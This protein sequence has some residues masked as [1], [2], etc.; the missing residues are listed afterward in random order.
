MDEKDKGTEGL[1]DKKVQIKAK[2]EKNQELILEHQMEEWRYLNEY[3]NKINLDYQRAIMLI[4]AI[5]A[6]LLAVFSNEKDKIDP[7]VVMIIPPV[8]LV[9]DAWQS[10]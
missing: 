2:R 9:V 5:S 4:S 10:K 6:I 8:I 3:V 1:P 7:L